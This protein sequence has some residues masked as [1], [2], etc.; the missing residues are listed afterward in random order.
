MRAHENAP[1]WWDR[2]G[3]GYDEQC[4]FRIEMVERQRRRDLETDR[5]SQGVAGYRPR[6]NLWPA[7][8]TCRHSKPQQAPLSVVFRAVEAQ[9]LDRR[10][11]GRRL[12]FKR[13][14]VVRPGEVIAPTLATRV[15]EF[16]FRTRERVRAARMRSLADNVALVAGDR[17]VVGVIGWRCGRQ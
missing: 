17:E 1:T 15:E 4:V 13:Q 11:P 12:A 10:P 16:N 5:V 3:C 8:P 6:P 2:G 9:D 14:V 7:P